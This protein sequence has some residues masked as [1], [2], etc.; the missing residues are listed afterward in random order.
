MNT[1]THRCV[2]PTRSGYV[3]LNCS[4]SWTQLSLIDTP[5]DTMTTQAP[6]RVGQ[7]SASVHPVNAGGKSAPPPLQLSLDSVS[8]DQ[9]S[10]SPKYFHTVRVYSSHGKLY[11]RYRCNVGHDITHDEHIPGGNVRSAVAKN[12]ATQVKRWIDQGRTP[13]EI[14]SNIGKWRAR[15]K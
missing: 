12:R 8:I 5:T 15:S 1:C 3:C 6:P 2:I 14:V 11:Y 13:D 7:N 9:A 4:R 10:V